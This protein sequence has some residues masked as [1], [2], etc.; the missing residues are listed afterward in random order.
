MPANTFAEAG[1]A[2]R[3]CRL[4]GSEPVVFDIDSNRVSG[5]YHRAVQE[6]L[7]PAAASA[8]MVGSFS[9]PDSDRT[10]LA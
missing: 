5:G 8:A 3:K 9:T 2:P 4:N 7:K 10:C 6:L 1:H